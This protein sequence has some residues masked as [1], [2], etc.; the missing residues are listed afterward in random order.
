MFGNN[1]RLKNALGKGDVNL[2]LENNQVLIV[3]NVYFVPGITKSLLS[4]CQATKNGTSIKFEETYAQIKHKTP[5]GQITKYIRK[6]LDDGLYRIPCTPTAITLEAHYTSTNEQ[7]T[8]TNLWHHRLAHTH[9]QAI[10]NMQ[11]HNMALGLP[12]AH[13]T[14]LKIF[15]GCILGKMP[16]HPFPCWQTTSSR[17][18]QLFH[19]DLYGPFPTKSISGSIYLISFIDEFIVN[20][21]LLPS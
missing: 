11:F 9:L 13:L 3:D 17:P 19:N 2:F 4:V 20:S 18:L 10:K 14:N 16:Q 1:G 5:D 15:E 8:L 6:H 7:S 21:S 12:K